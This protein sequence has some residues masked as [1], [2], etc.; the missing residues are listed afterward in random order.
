MTSKQSINTAAKAST[1]ETEPTLVIVDVPY[2]VEE[3]EQPFGKRWGGEIMTLTKEHLVALQ[4]GKL[5]AVDVMN[6]YVVFLRL[7]AE[8]TNQEE[9]KHDRIKF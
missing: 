5:V 1:V 7:Q 9:E 6:E 8:V 2:D 4:E 3:T